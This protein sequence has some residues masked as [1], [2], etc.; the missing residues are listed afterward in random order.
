[1]RIIEGIMNIPET[2]MHMDV[3]VQRQTLCFVLLSVMNGARQR[4]IKRGGGAVSRS[5]VNVLG[6]RR[7]FVS[8]T[9]IKGCYSLPEA[10][11]A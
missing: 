7:S 6:D 4:G 3:F 10:R 5:A 1:M 8:G 11:R 9:S 2:S